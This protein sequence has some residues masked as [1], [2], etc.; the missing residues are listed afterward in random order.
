M[1]SIYL[2]KER[3]IPENQIVDSS[4]E[5]YSGLPM[6]FLEGLLFQSYSKDPSGSE[7]ETYASRYPE[8]MDMIKLTVLLN[9]NTMIV[10]TGIYGVL[11]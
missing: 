2:W 4:I 3:F 8:S 9:I 6:Y 11:V 5:G 10:D 1:L 7:D